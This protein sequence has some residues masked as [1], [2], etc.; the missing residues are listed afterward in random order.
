MDRSRKTQKQP[1][2]EE[3]KVQRANQRADPTQKYPNMGYKTG[4]K[5][6]VPPTSPPGGPGPQP[7]Y[8]PTQPEDQ[9]LNPGTRNYLDLENFKDYETDDHHQLDSHGPE[10]NFSTLEKGQRPLTTKVGK[11]SLHSSAF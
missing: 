4:R 1:M 11:C 5:S 10:R 6:P 8:P 2:T 7:G 9:D 3:K